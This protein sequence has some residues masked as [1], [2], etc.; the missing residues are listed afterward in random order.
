MSTVGPAPNT[1][2]RSRPPT[3]SGAT[4]SAGGRG[5]C[6]PPERH[7]TSVRPPSSASNASSSRTA[8]SW[9][10]SSADRAT[11][12]A[13]ASSTSSR[14]SDPSAVTQA[15]AA[16][17]TAATAPPSAVGSSSSRPDGISCSTRER[18]SPASSSRSAIPESISRPHRRVA[19]EIMAGVSSAVAAEVTRSTSSC[20]S[21]M[22]VRSCSGSTWCSCSASIASSAWLVTTMSARPASPRAC[23]AKQSSPTGQ[24][25]APRHSWA[26]TDTCRHACSDTPG[27]SSSRS[28]VSV[29]EDHSCSR[30]T[31]RPIRET[32]NGS[33]SPV[34]SGSSGA[35]VCTRCRHR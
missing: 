27:T 3:P 30:L 6:S 28:P 35:P 15:W 10:S 11:L 8:V 33:N 12:R 7:T 21:S 29:S 32:A 4:C 24:R 1:R 9:I 16:S 34:S 25:C 20:A 26:V 13:V 18:P 5:L 22:T 31:S 14:R 23:S 17:R 2:S 19:V